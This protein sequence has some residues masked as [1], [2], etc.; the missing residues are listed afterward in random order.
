MD[1]NNQPTTYVAETKCPGKEI[2]GLVLGINSL[3]FGI[4]AVIFGW[5]PLIGVAYGIIFALMGIGVGIPAVVLWSKVLQQA[6]V[7]TKKGLIGKNLGLAGII[8]SACGVVIS[9][10]CCAACSADYINYLR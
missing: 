9:I 7:T 3:V 10:I 5:I 6:T 1:Y 8:V 2:A 4:F